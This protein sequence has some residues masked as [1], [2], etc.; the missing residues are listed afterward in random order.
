MKELL[1][2]IWL[3]C[4]ATGVML[5]IS[6]LIY[7]FFLGLGHTFDLRSCLLGA[8]A[9]GWTLFFDRMKS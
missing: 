3:C 8:G 9:A 7:L 1:R 2:I 4:A 6:A 5:G